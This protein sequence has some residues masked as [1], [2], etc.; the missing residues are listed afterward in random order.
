MCG[1]EQGYILHEAAEPLLGKSQVERR[2]TTQAHI[3]R[4]RGADLDLPMASGGRSPTPPR[5][6]LNMPDA[7]PANVFS[8][9]WVMFALALI[10]A[11]WVHCSYHREQSR[12]Y[13]AEDVCRFTRDSPD[14]RRCAW[15][16]VA[17]RTIAVQVGWST[18]LPRQHMVV[19]FYLQLP[20]ALYCCCSTPHASSNP[21]LKHMLCTHSSK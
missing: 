21:N 19:Q 1:V 5:R 8:A 16:A 3:M 18:A 10:L 15:P 17:Y 6:Q 2:Y 7:T 11:G 12:L 4:R 9:T 13:C 14:N 20:V